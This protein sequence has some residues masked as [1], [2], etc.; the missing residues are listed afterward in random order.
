MKNIFRDFIYPSIVMVFSIICL[1]LQP[2]CYDGI[3]FI[4]FV[5]LIGCALL[6]F[7]IPIF[8]RIFKIDIPFVFNY[9]VCTHIVISMC[10]GNALKFYSLISWWDLLAHGLF[11]A[12]CTC[13]LLVLFHNDKVSM[14]F[15]YFLSTVGLGGL[16]E[17]FEYSADVLSGSDTQKVQESLDKGKL[18]QAD[19]MEDIVIT[20]VGSL[21][22]IAF[23]YLIK[24]IVNQRKKKMI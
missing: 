19:T 12:I 5:Q 15:L 13:G 10:L 21:F 18:P 3:T 9:L 6:C 17:V 8:T 4:N 14:M 20:I 22:F 11:G 2:F 16:W 24:Y 7:V 23:Y 1:I